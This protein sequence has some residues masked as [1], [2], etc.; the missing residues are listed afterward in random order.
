[1]EN[2]SERPNVII[3]GAGISGLIA[4]RQ[5]EALGY[6]PTIL[7]AD[8]QAGGRVQTDIVAG[9]QLDRGFQVLLEAYPKAQTY[10]DYQALA[11]Q[12]LDDGSMLFQNGIGNLFGDPRRDRR[13]L[14]PTV[15]SKHA[16]LWDKWK[17]YR[18][19]TQ[20]AKKELSD[21]FDAPSRT[22]HDY[23]KSLGFSAKVISS[24]FRPFF[25]GIFLEDQLS[26]SSRMFEFVF[27][28]FGEGSA[29]I[30]K[31]GM[32]AIPQQLQSGLKQ[33]KFLFN[34]RVKQVVGTN[35]IL[36]N[37]ERLSGDFTILAGNP[38]GILPNYVSTLNW[39]SCENLYFT[40]KQRT[41]LEPIIGLNT[42]ENRLTNNIF[43]PTSISCETK[44]EEELLSVTVVK[45]HSM[46][47]D[48]L[49]EQV[50][51]ELKQDFGINDVSFLKRY[52]ITEA[53]PMLEDLQAS[54]DASEQ[55]LTDNIAL[56]GDYLLN[57]SLNAAMESGEK[58][59]AIAHAT[60]QNHVGIPQ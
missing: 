52:T 20:L 44:G 32:G 4:A 56:A 16:S 57:G 42:A 30:P 60:L 33:T 22:T 15:F 51:S 7:E 49:I 50:R 39:K 14:L 11:L 23:L 1:M 59:A 53:L 10:L 55:L 6:S 17:I 43:F 12:K 26:T 21:V 37:G 24:F 13:F 48:V 36:E 41:I 27:K 58:A 47:E 29:M 28:M 25:S 46:S 19:N 31:A 35:I 8:K 38:S 3:I 45:H 2:S 40:T 54:R 18:L 34:T 5:L 9:Y